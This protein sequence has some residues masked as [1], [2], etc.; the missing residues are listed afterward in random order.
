M[1]SVFLLRVRVFR[2]QLEQLWFFPMKEH[3]E[4]R[5]EGY[6][7]S[8]D[9]GYLQNSEKF[10]HPTTI[11]NQFRCHS[12][13]YNLD[14]NMLY[15]WNPFSTTGS[16]NTDDNRCARYV[17][18]QQTSDCFFFGENQFLIDADNAIAPAKKI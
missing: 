14:R 15:L 2:V 11:C 9:T 8:L 1:L 16:P 6:K 10:K 5:Y 4:N 17:T 12:G 3:R 13:Q 18:S 7:S